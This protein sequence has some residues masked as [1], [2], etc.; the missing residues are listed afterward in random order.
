MLRRRSP[1][2][3]AKWGPIWGPLKILA[4][5]WPPIM[6]LSDMAIRRAK[7]GPKPIKLADE[8]GLFLLLQPSGGKLWRLKYRLGGKEKKLGLGR[9]PDVTLR[10]ARKRRDE[11]RAQIATGVDPGAQRQAQALAAKLNAATTFKCLGEEYLTKASREGRAAVTIKKSRWLFSLL[12]PGLGALPIADITPAQLLAVIRKVEAKGHLE[13]ARR[14][15][16][17]AGRIFRYAVA[18]SRATGDPSGL[19]RGALT[20]PK[21]K[22][23]SAV[24][25]TEQVGPL[26]RAIEGYDGQPLTCIALKL[27][28]HLFVRPGELRRAEWTELDLEAAVWTIPPEKMKMRDPHVVPLSRQALK[29]LQAA[30]A[31]SAGQRYV[32]SS[33]YPGN[34]PMSENTINAALRRIG[35]LGTEMT[36]HGFR[37]MASTLLNESGMWSVD[38]IERALAHKDGSTTRGAYHR[39][40]HWAERVNM[41]QWWSDHLET[42]R[43]GAELISLLSSAQRARD[44]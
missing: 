4:E 37:A 9:Y 16:S 13:T 25:Q 27:T 12:E 19:L 26:L 31:I 14:M 7:H 39:G 18:T 8:K 28:P 30:Q 20:A 42:L 1:A 40:L 33:L 11:A 34:R 41:A 17:L 6:A 44:M 35:Y 15:R 22:H 29:L 32:F 36:A 3:A 10:E 24:I 43:D 5:E 38:A 2:F 21:V 23:H